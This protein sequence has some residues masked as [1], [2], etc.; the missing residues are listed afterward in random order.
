M[1]ATQP[2]DDGLTATTG[3]VRPIH[4]TTSY[5]E[6]ERFVDDLSDR[7]FAVEQLRIVGRGLR[8]VEQ[9]T[10]RMTKGR[11]ALAGAATGA[12]FGVFIG[13]LFALF[14]VGP[15]WWG[16]M[17]WSIV[18]GAVFGAVFGFA[19]HWAT[20]GRRDF[21]SVSGLQADTY[22]VQVDADHADEALRLVQRR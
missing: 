3:G 22:E 15:A 18:I 13:L 14:V 8:S 7:G 19:G 4:E 1:S 21:T 10:G 12:W 17:L 5:S 20:R 16:M 6:A 2:D 9:V 11:A